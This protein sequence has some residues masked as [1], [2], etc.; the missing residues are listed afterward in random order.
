MHFPVY[1]RQEAK[2]WIK[3]IVLIAA[4]LLVQITQAQP[5]KPDLSFNIADDGV[6]TD[7]PGSA[8]VYA[9]AKYL[10]G[11]TVMGG[12]FN[13]YNNN[14]LYGYIAALNNNGSHLP[15]YQPRPQGRIRV[16]TPATGGKM[17]IGG[18]FTSIVGSSLRYIAR[19]NENGTL[20]NTFSDGGTGASSNVF[21]V[22]DQG[23][24]AVIGGNF[25][26]YNGSTAS[27]I[28][29]LTNTGAL[30]ATFQS[31]TGANNQ[32]LAMQF[33]SDGK[34]IITGTFTSYNGIACNRI[35]RLNADGSFDNTFNIGSGLNNPAISMQIA[36]D[37]KIY[38]GG[39]FS[40]YNGIAAD[41][42]LR[43]NA[44][45]TL[46]N[47]FNSSQP[48][49]NG[50]ETICLQ[51]DGK[52]VVGGGITQYNGVAVNRIFRVNT[53]GSIDAT[54]NIGTGA[55]ST[56]RSIYLQ[57]DGSFL[58]GGD[59]TFMNGRPRKYFVKLSANGT[60]DNSFAPLPGANLLVNKVAVQAD[61]KIL[62]GGR[63][64]SLNNTA[65]QFIGRLNADGTTD[66][67]FD[68]GISAEAQVNDIGLQSSGK[69]IY[70]FQYTNISTGDYQDCLKR[71]NTDGSEDVTY[72]KG[73]VNFSGSITKLLVLPDDKIMI[74]GDFNTFTT[75]SAPSVFR[76]RLARLNAD[77]TIDAGFTPVSPNNPVTEM[78]VQADGKTIIYGTFTNI[79]GGKTFVRLNTD[80]T[81]DNDF[82]TG[83]AFA[84]STVSDI[85]VQPDGKILVGGS[86]S[87]YNGL[88]HNRIVR[89]MPDG[90]VDPT[91]VTG[92]G[93]GG[94]VTNILLQP[95]GKIILTGTIFS[96]QGTN[97]TGRAIRLNPDGS[98]DMC[99]VA[100][101]DPN[102]SVTSIAFQNINNMIMVGDFSAVNQVVKHR[103]VRIN[104]GSCVVPVRL[105]D[106]TAK[107]VG[108]QVALQWNTSVE[109]NSSHFIVERSFNGNDFEAIGSVAAAGNS[110]STQF[111]HFADPLMNQ[112][113]INKNIFYRLQMV[114]L[115]A[116]KEQSKTAVV[117]MNATN[118]NIQVIKNPVS[119]K[120]ECWYYTSLKNTM[121]ISLRDATGRL[122]YSQ[123]KSPLAGNNF[124]SI[125]AA[126]LGNGIYYIRITQSS[127]N[128]SAR[129]LLV[130]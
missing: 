50:V 21:C 85:A 83:T 65:K 82:I 27:R 77:G 76:G 96:Y 70:A 13:A 116:S 117:K 118:N 93:F 67:S 22:L 122:V 28:A 16:L 60:V 29:R 79:A 53:D 30:D 69:I 14:S 119:D 120:I 123:S 11:R 101:T 1:K 18:D 51:A 103:I 78:A 58:V 97:F 56:V 59:F 8:G 44:D 121:Y 88:T 108:K 128:S 125:P 87:S 73:R 34:I 2:R 80:G 33:Q 54:F 15:D 106:F 109:Q 95:D 105:L 47:S 68:A 9:F 89:L 99:Y 107:Q 61:Q 57:T 12:G 92:T 41:R 72:N 127:S 104:T 52:L 62:L 94:T 3:I 81:V 55:N 46:D 126:G 75:A 5:G 37:N 20:D 40:T 32:V 86:F 64:T 36:P 39:L 98:R 25:S 84:A 38:L 4:L 100:G 102:G 23:G 113:L 91:F 111:Y 19:V 48:A 114:D 7:G 43:L 74:A 130:N 49:L 115:D 24:K 35:A 63:F 90:S 45:G 110:N 42:L 66:N 124:I 6:F 129:V 26:T 71:L 17:Y 112:T 31:G 10:T